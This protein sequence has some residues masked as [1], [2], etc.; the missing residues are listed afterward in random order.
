MSAVQVL[1][2]GACDKPGP[3]KEDIATIVEVRCTCSHDLL[4]LLVHMHKHSTLCEQLTIRLHSC[5]SP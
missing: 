4:L 5:H 1:I 2:Y 3:N